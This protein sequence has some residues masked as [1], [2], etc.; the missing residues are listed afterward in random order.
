[1]LSLV[2]LKIK[3]V[4]GLK[5]QSMRAEILPTKLPFVGEMML[6]NKKR[7]RVDKVD[8]DTIGPRVIAKVIMTAT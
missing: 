6:L 7:V 8:L 1:M 2:S 5:E 3:Y 4:D